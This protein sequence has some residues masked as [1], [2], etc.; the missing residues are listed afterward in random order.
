MR[1][2][3]AGFT[4]IELMIVV[5]I[6]GILMVIALPMMVGAKTSAHDAAAKE[7]A[8]N[9][10]K[11]AKVIYTDDATFTPATT[12]AL[13][14]VEPTLIYVDGATISTGPG[15][16]STDSPDAA[17]TGNTMVIA[18]YSTSGSCFFLRDYAPG[19]LAFGKLA[20]VASSECYAGNTAAVAFGGSW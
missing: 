2:D 5:L 6:V 9:A 13:R 3:E 17:T 1:N 14:A 15:T 16:V 10:M 12:A 18:V 11:A 19:T 8:A 7:S 4:L 20:Q